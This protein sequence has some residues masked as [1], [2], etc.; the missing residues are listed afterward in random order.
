MTLKK[1]YTPNWLLIAGIPATIFSVCWLITLFPFYQ[2][3]IQSLSLAIA[4]DLLI[5][6]PFCYYLLIRNTTVNKVTVLRI[7]FIGLILTGM[8]V[9]LESLPFLRATKKWMAPTLEAALIL[10]IARKFYRA[11]KEARLHRQANPDFLILCRKILL[12]VTGNDKISNVLAA[13]IAVFYYAFISGKEKAIDNNMRFSSYK[14]NSTIL[15]L[16]TFLCLFVIETT[17]VHFL[18]MLWNKTF[19]WFITTLSIYTCL[20]LLSHIRAIK[21]R[22]IFIGHDGLQ[23]T[24]GLAADCNITFKNIREI[25]M[26][27]KNS[28]ASDAVKIALIN[29]MESHNFIIHLHEPVTVTKMFG[30]QKKSQT[31]LFFVDQPETFLRAINA[32]L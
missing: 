6:A 17:G 11:T 19:A 18:L 10:F 7:L 26:T 1:I 23:L 9:N 31:I 25:E 13:E 29:G 22:S 3:H 4:G 12:N 5:T 8:I 30:I 20:Q 2:Q 27:K 14:Q 21:A 32:A 24:M 16:L 15:F 28:I